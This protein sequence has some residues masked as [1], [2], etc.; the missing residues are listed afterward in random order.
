VLVVCFHLAV[1]GAARCPPQ[2]VIRP[3]AAEESTPW[4]AESRKVGDTV[5]IEAYYAVGADQMIR[6]IPPPFPRERLDLYRRKAPPGQVAARPHG[7]YAMVL[8]WRPDGLIIWGQA[9]GQGTGFT[10]ESLVEFTL[11][12]HAPAFEGESALLRR[13][14]EG[15]IV[16]RPNA[17]EEQYLQAVRNAVAEAWP[18]IRL[19]IEFHEADRAVIQLEGTWHYAAL[20]AVAQDRRQIEVYGRD[21]NANREIGGGGTGN[22]DDFAGWLGCWI[23]DQ[24]IVEAEDLPPRISWHLNGEGTGSVDS[25][26]ASHDRRL[27]L[28]HI[29]EQ[30]GLQW[31][32][33]VRRV[34]RLFV[35]QA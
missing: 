21:L 19:S 7:P 29:Q 31:S 11:R 17:T 20:D 4:A 15:D 14:L 5:N 12:I 1:V 28:D 9:F 33:Q 10:F 2:I 24:V 6:R 23:G 18:E 8:H 34:R 25:R 35:Q 27:V 3:A 13:E 30:T 22:A 26:S 32:E 16:I